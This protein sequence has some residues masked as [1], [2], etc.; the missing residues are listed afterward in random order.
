MSL[1]TS[2]IQ[3]LNRVDE[4]AVTDRIAD[5]ELPPRLQSVAEAY[6]EQV[7][8][9]DPFFWQW[10]YAS[11]HRTRLSTVP[12]EH[13]ETVDVLKTL[14]GMYDTIV[15]DIVDAVGE[16]QH[17]DTVAR[18]ALEDIDNPESE[19]SAS[20]RTV[21]AH[22]RFA[23][24]V[25]TAFESM[26]ESAPREEQFRPLL[27]FDI[28]QILM[29]MRYTLL[30]AANP[31]MTNLEEGLG[32]QSHNLIHFLNADIDMMYST[33]FDRADIGQLRRLIWDGQQLH[34]MINWIATWER[35]LF[36]GDFSSGV[37]A[38]ALREGIVDSEQLNRIRNGGGDP[39][40]VRDAI[41]DHAVDQ[42]LL[43]E[44][45]RR[46]AETFETASQIQT[47]SVD[48]VDYAIGVREVCR[49]TLAVKG[50]V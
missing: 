31:A 34:R 46:Y 24:R 22:L 7:G 44:W 12:S 43:E 39:D 40:A 28:R 35:E 30:V 2:N 10:M 20:D 18:I 33:A 45:E 50:D 19:L 15:D 4:Q 38:L 11:M 23:L 21:E 25:W 13:H 37:F 9:R 6:D 3:S 36:E 27:E 47:N 1:N 8:K 26:L 14:G 42:R 16:P 48:V 5:T 41:T 17:L 49:D 29:S 32:Y